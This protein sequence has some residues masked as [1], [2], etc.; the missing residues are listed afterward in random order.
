[1]VDAVMKPK[2]S[3][4]SRLLLAATMLYAPSIAAAQETTPPAT[5]ETP[6]ST[7]ETEPAATEETEIVVQGRFIPAP[8]RETSEVATFLSSADLA[9]TGDDT[10]AS[11]LTRLTGLSVV[12]DRFVFVRGLGDRYSAAMLNGSPLP[13]PEPLRR[14]VPL[15]LFPSNILSGATVQ[16]TFS[17]NYP[18]EFG[19]GVIDLKT[20]RLPN[21]PFVTVK[22]GTGGNTE[23]TGKEGFFYYGSRTD[24][25]S[26]DNGDREIPGL[27]AGAIG[28]RRRIDD[29][30]YTPAQLEAF[31][32]SLLNSPVTVVQ[33]EKRPLDF[34]GEIT[35]GTSL[36][37]GEFNL[38]LV[39]VFGYDNNWR[40]KN[41]RKTEV[42]GNAVGADFDSTT[43]TNDI[44]LNAFGSASL[45]WKD[46]ELTLSTLFVRSSTKFTQVQTGIDFD[47]PGADP[48]NPVDNERTE[49]TAWYERQLASVQLAGE[50]D[51]DDL[52]LKLSWRT[53]FAQ[54]TRDAP[55]ERSVRYDI[56]AGQ[57]IFGGGGGLGNSIRFSELTDEVASAGFD[58]NYTIPLSETRD[59]VISAGAAYS[60]TKRTSELYQFA[61][62]G[63][64]GPTPLDVLR[65]RID[66]LF[67]PD[68]IAPTRFVLNE[69][70]GRDDSYEG[71]LT[72][73]AFYL[74]ADVEAIPLVRTSF[75]FRYEDA[76]QTVRTFNRFGEASTRPVRLENAYWLPAVT[77]TWNFAEDL[78]LR[79]GYSET[80]ARPQFRELAF[81][82]FIDPDSDLVYQGNPL[83]KD[84]T[85]K[86]YD[87]RVEYYFGRDRFVTGGL[88]YKQIENPIEEVV[89][90]TNRYEA[91]F[92]NAPEATLW[93]VELEYRTKFEMPFD[94]PFLDGEEWLFAINYTYTKSEVNAPAGSTVINPNTF[95]PSPATE[96][97]LDGSA[98]QGTP[99][100][101]ANLQFGYETDSQQMTLLVG[102]VDERIL[103][104][105]LGSTL[106]VIEDPGVNVDLV[107]K[108]DFKIGE[109]DFTL[110]VSGR[111]LLGT[112]Y[113]EFQLY[114]RGRNDVNSY[115]KGS[116]IS[117]SLSAKY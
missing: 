116:S 17:P 117:V 61:F 55:Y 4:L 84:S 106:P 41:A 79:L 56:V 99:E 57:P 7:G 104:R 111:N 38:G 52:S 72:N 108:Q 93:G 13:S 33:R 20:L 32:E 15:D 101:I 23:S 30:N 69:T 66:F 50:H 114:P 75:G 81:T 90:R 76:T 8:M 48:L 3:M 58:L 36:D 82:P 63:P 115:D 85:F 73:T 102:W 68:N 2:T 92:I 19:G 11:A 77:V 88:F 65:A 25:T 107:F 80:V 71:A 112:R 70:T 51:F 9:R 60:D 18:G 28:Q 22:I 74:M 47:L 100:N 83:L 110:G 6:V 16:K 42:V 24:W 45:N 12:S 31:G 54:S 34:E 113:E 27:I 67:S 43:T 53:A 78:Q 91:R 49:E 87:A 97:A 14:Q 95:L 59:M 96:F 1:M 10:A 40:T 5:P 29:T 44:V 98:L 103:R 94:V 62:T 21:Q 35:A 105:G 26:W 37:I 46:N 109:Q 86:N 39:G 89:F 64:R